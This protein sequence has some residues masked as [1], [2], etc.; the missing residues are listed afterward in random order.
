MESLASLGSLADQALLVALA[1]TRIAVAF[2]LLPVL[3]PD[4]VPALVRN[5][6]F[7]AFGIVTLALQPSVDVTGWAAAGWLRLFVKEA[8]LG[9]AMG[10][11]LGA[12]LWAFESAGQ[13]VDAKAGLNLAQVVDPLSGQQTSLSGALLGRLANFVFMFSGGLL[14]WVGTLLQSFAVWPLAQAS[15]TL[16]PAGVVLFEQ[17]FAQY[18]LLAFLLAAPALVVL[19]AIDFALGL[20]N[21]YAPQLNLISISMSL[22]GV[23]ATLVWLLMLATVLNTLIEQVQRLLPGMLGRLQQTVG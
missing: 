19:Y 22:K 5:A 11:L 3:A 13:L 6:L 15:L 21:R 18:A 17:A 4:I 23:A 10:L 8:F 16:K 20:M 12:V 7:I 2:L 9:I 1:S 14:L